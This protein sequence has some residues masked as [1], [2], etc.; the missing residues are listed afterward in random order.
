MPISR[1][2]DKE[3]ISGNRGRGQTEVNA[4]TP[5]TPLEQRFVTNFIKTGDA[6]KSLKEAGYTGNP[7]HGSRLLSKPNIQAEINKV[8]DDL[9]K[10]TRATAEEVMEYFTAV[11]RG[12]IK[13]Q[14][15]LDAPLGERTKAAQELAKRTIDIENKKAGYGDNTINVTLKWD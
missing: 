12:E 5:L 7:H 9:R 3:H 1:P 11:M 8:M 15:G 14:F 13:D 2:K 4:D 10:E 6:V